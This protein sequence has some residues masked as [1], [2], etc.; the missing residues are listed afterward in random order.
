MKTMR[1]VELSRVT[2]MCVR[3]CDRGERPREERSR[4]YNAA[5]PVSVVFWLFFFLGRSLCDIF[6]LTD[7]L[8][9][10]GGWQE[11]REGQKSLFKCGKSGV[12]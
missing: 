3:V 5:E 2:N 9:G 8:I 1:F 10:G 7:V 4:L 12:L 11:K 6:G